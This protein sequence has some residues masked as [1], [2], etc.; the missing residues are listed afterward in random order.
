MIDEDIGM[1]IKYVSMSRLMIWAVVVV[2]FVH[3]VVHAL[4]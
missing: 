3:L 4:S 1:I 2:L